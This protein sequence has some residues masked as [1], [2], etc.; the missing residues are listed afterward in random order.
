MGGGF[1][2]GHSETAGMRWYTTGTD[3]YSPKLNPTTVLGERQHGDVK[4]FRQ[5]YKR[6]GLV[7]WGISTKQQALNGGVRWQNNRQS[8]G[9]ARRNNS[10]RWT[11]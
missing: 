10:A 4:S 6:S 3:M 11:S 8:S 5:A 2:R 1:L 7:E 9:G